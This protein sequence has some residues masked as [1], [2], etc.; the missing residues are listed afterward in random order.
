[1]S[2]LIDKKL[3]DKCEELALPTKVTD[4]LLMYNENIKLSLLED[5]LKFKSIIWGLLIE[6]KKETKNI[7]N[8]WNGE[9]I[10]AI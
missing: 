8:K 1:M 10:F 7:I 5:S 4:T 2:N 9:I 6:I 3:L